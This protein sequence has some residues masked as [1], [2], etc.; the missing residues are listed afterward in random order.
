[1]SRRPRALRWP[2][3]ASQ[4]RC[5][6]GIGRPLGPS[7]LG[8]WA[9]RRL[10]PPCTWVGAPI[11]RAAR[12]DGQREH[13]LEL[14]WL[15]ARLELRG[16][17]GRVLTERESRACEAGGVG[18]RFSVDVIERGGRREKRWPDLVLEQPGRRVAIEPSRVSRRPSSQDAVLAGRES[19]GRCL[20]QGSTTMSCASAPFGWCSSP[21]VRSR[22]LPGT[23]ACT[24][25][26]A[27]VGAPGRGRLRHARR[28][29]DDGRA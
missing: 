8:L 21:A 12:T 28:S 17:T 7:L 29:P 19:A 18:R 25:D 1:M 10:D 15:V 3:R 16:G 11:R 23:W 22:T 5:L 26:A 6:S 9:C 13:E 14:A 20:L 4:Q 2:A 27:A 24:G